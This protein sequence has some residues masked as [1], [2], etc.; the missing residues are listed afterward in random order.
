M[1]RPIE[2]LRPRKIPEYAVGPQH[3]FHRTW[4]I[5]GFGEIPQDIR[6]GFHR[7]LGNAG[8]GFTRPGAKARL[9]CGGIIG[10]SVLSEAFHGG[11]MPR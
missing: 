9:A 2:R 6:N 8:R 11:S 4:G 10:K 7:F 5:V 3:F 1:R